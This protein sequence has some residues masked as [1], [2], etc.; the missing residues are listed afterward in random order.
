[1]IV[2]V[3]RIVELINS[4]F[5]HRVCDTQRPLKRLEARNC[6]VCMCCKNPYGFL[7]WKIYDLV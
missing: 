3:M 6:F 1:M 5:F 2:I 4:S 7:V